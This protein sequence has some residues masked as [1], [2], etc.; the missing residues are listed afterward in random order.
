M[1]RR[2]DSARTLPGRRRFLAGAGTLAAAA[3]ASAAF[4]AIVPA[5]VFGQN[6]PSN[7]INVG[8]IGTGRISRAHDL[9][10][11]W[12]HEHA[13]IMAVCDLDS[14]R[15]ADA[16]ALVNGFYTKQSGKP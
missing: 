10:G 4:P 7:R 6:A 2:T 9:P 12:K 5:T 13:R 11:I 1:N 3:G 14:T 15:V 16:R 8:A